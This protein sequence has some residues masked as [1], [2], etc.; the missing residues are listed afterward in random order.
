MLNTR[1]DVEAAI[2]KADRASSTDQKEALATLA[3]A[4][5][6]LLIA[7]ELHGRHVGLSYSPYELGKRDAP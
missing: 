6:L 5:A 7:D 1:A 3:V 2:E 4:K